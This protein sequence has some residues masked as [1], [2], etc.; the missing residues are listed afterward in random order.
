V[1]TIL[2][3]QG[4]ALNLIDSDGWVKQTGTDEVSGV[5]YAKTTSKYGKIFKLIVS[6]PVIKSKVSPTSQRERPSS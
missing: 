2:E 5:V 6:V 1:T 3:A 4:E